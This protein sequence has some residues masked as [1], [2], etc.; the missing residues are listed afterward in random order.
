MYDWLSI[1]FV[2]EIKFVASYNNCENYSSYSSYWN[3]ITQFSHMILI[4]HNDF[5]L[6]LSYHCTI[7][8]R[9]IPCPFSALLCVTG[10][11]IGK[12]C[13][14]FFFFCKLCSSSLLAYGWFQLMQ[15]CGGK[16]VD[17]KKGEPQISLPHSLLQQWLIS[18]S[19]APA[20][21]SLLLPQPWCCRH[22][23][24]Q[25]V[26][27]SGLTLQTPAFP[28]AIGQWGPPA[29]TNMGAASLLPFCMFSFANTL[30][31]PLHLNL[32]HQTTWCGSHFHAWSLTD[33]AFPL[34]LLSDLFTFAQLFSKRIWVI[35]SANPDCFPHF[36][37]N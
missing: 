12:L 29:R 22:S 25:P 1:A 31:L 36:C 7:L 6:H 23:S 13:S 17:G 20:S 32:L 34:V 24:C 8:H 37:R 3:L 15:V 2:Y 14:F 9:Y 27:V 28:P 4:S 30:S 21:M 26:L 16:R 18:H 10:T 5:A 35:T 33:R 19:K 11:I